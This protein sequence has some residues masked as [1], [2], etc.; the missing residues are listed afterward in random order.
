M[1]PIINGLVYFVFS[2][3]IWAQNPDL[4]ILPDSSQANI[5]T[6]Q[7]SWLISTSLNS[8]VFSAG[9]DYGNSQFG[10]FPAVFYNHPAGFFA[11]WTGS[12]Y[13]DTTLT[14][15]Q[16]NVNL[17]FAGAFSAAWRYSLS[18]S[19]TF[20]HPSEEGLLSNGLGLAS[21]ISFGAFNLGTSFTAMLGEEKGYRVNLFSSAYWA[22]GQKG[23]LSNAAFAPSLSALMG[24]ENIPFYTLP[25]GQF[26]RTTGTRWL[27]RKRIV[28]NPRSNPENSGNVFGLMS[29][30][31]A[32]PL[33]YYAGNWTFNL[34]PNLIFPIPLPGETYPESG[35]PK[36][37]F[38][39]TFSRRF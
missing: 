28:T 30:N 3:I 33:Y 11:G 15:T 17:G 37:S 38:G 13:G 2:S 23:W 8:R 7:A 34:A 6:E 4:R 5:P 29:I 12:L 19:H 32:L 1:K 24:T 14:Y 20:F 27:E 18:Y 25:L 21:D 35:E 39:F 16:S 9:R 36:I 26:E 10:V 31:L 22:L